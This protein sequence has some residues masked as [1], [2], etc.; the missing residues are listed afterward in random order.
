MGRN[1][2]PKLP[3]TCRHLKNQEA[4][5]CAATVFPRER[6]R[7]TWHHSISHCRQRELK[8]QWLVLQLK[9]KQKKM[10]MMVS[11][12]WVAQH[13]LKSMVPLHSVVD[14]NLLHALRFWVSNQPPCWWI[15]TQAVSELQAVK[16]IKVMVRPKQCGPILVLSLRRWP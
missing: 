7:G 5:T 3:I 13:L 4:A 8:C 11:F 1:F 14:G 9:K 16:R 12:I 6:S 2:L 15:L 10:T